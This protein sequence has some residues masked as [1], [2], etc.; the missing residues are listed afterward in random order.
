MT[1]AQAVEVLRQVAELAQSKGILSLKD[2]AIVLQAI[3]VLYPEQEQEQ[4]AEELP[5]TDK[6]KKVTK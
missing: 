3:T 4:E 2:S 6:K 5:A 1:P